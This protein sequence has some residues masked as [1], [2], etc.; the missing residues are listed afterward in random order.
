MIEGRLGY[1]LEGVEDK[2]R[3][4]RDRE[5]LHNLIKRL[6]GTEDVLGFIRKELGL[7]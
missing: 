7:I 3:D 1:V 6:V 2:V 5:Y 4:I